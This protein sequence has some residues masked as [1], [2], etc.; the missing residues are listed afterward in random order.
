VKAGAKVRKHPGPAPSA[1]DALA[2]SVRPVPFRKI[3]T[4]A[5]VHASVECYLRAHPSYWRRLP[6]CVVW[7]DPEWDARSERLMP[8]PSEPVPAPAMVAA[9]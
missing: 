7:A 2:G 3:P 6:A 1:V 8:V 5:V 9:T 4:D